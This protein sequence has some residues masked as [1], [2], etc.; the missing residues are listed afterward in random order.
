MADKGH[1][2]LANDCYHFVRWR[3]NF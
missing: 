2:G 3:S 1:H